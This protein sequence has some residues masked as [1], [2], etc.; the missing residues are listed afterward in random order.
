MPSEKLIEKMRSR[1]S[2]PLLRKRFDEDMKR[3]H[4]I[5]KKVRENH[6]EDL[7]RMEEEELA[8]ISV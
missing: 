4:E 8:A 2:D 3:V 5:D 7:L 6:K 1:I